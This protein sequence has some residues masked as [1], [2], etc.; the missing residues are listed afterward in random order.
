MSGSPEENCE[1]LLN[2]PLR[3]W[4]WFGFSTRMLITLMLS[5]V[6]MKSRTF[7]SFLYSANEQKGA[8]PDS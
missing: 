4:L 5:A 7:S 8:Q 2:L 3:S 6:A 1:P